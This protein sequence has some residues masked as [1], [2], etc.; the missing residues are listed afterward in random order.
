[1]DNIKQG[2]AAAWNLSSK[3]YD[4]QYAHG[5]K[6]ENEKKQWKLF[7]SKMVGEEKKEILDVGTGTGFLAILLA[8]LGH[9][10][11]GIDLSE[12]MMEVAKSKSE[13]QCL[14]INFDIGDAENLSYSDNTFDFVVNRHLLWTIPNP[15]KALN[16][17]I[18]V[19]KPGGTLMIIDGDWFYNNIWYEFKIFLGRILIAI[20]EFRNP[21][22]YEGAYDKNIRNNL[23][24]IKDKN[25]RNLYKMVKNTELID[26]KTTYLKEVDRAEK[27][28]MPLRYRLIN[29][30]KRLCITG[31][32][33][34]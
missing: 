1:M 23:P 22:K 27:M 28:A 33:K 20:T 25:A 12:G 6:S 16:E 31:V 9:R 21:W 11:T 4:N 18:R 30:H 10:C 5:L 26:V 7:L 15:E 29:P 34:V 3:N 32:K 24:M 8:E 13:S 19:L 17:W 14:D 2:I